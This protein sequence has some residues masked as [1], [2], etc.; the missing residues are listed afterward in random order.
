MFME[1]QILTENKISG[2]Q[3]TTKLPP[4]G[5]SKQ[6]PSWQIQVMMMSSKYLPIV[7]NC[8]L[9]LQF[10]EQIKSLRIYFPLKIK[11]Q[12]PKKLV[13]LHH[14]IKNNFLKH[15]AKTQ[16]VIITNLRNLFMRIVQ[17]KSVKNSNY[18]PFIK[19]IKFKAQLIMFTKKTN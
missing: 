7:S 6:S 10:P 15:K 2:T 8:H 17:Q 1:H 5:I 9:L 19:I 3:V 13:R 11:L 14:H 12:N 4:V 18:R 16:M